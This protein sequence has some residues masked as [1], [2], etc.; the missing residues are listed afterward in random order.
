MKIIRTVTVFAFRLSYLIYISN[1]KCRDRNNTYR[2][3]F[4]LT[5]QRSL[6]SGLLNFVRFFANRHREVVSC[7]EGGSEEIFAFS[8]CSHAHLLLKPLNFG[9]S[10]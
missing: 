1:Q 6:S 4:S 7:N 5:I 9:D 8:W 3:S 2:L 10:L